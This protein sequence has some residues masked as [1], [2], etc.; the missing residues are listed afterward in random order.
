MCVGGSRQERF[1][2]CVYINMH[3]PTE[4]RKECNCLSYSYD[5]RQSLI[6]ILK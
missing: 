1:A 3:A 4:T 2:S 5:I 6:S